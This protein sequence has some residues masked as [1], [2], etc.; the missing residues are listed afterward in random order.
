MKKEDTRELMVY[1]L[2]FA[3]III[4]YFLPSPYNT[5]SFILALV[6]NVIYLGKHLHKNTLTK[7]DFALTTILLVLTVTNFFI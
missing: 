1:L 5:I 2:I 4:Q 7:F 3:L 6:I